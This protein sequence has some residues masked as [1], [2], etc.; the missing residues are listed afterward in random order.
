[1]S[2]GVT[3]VDQALP[4]VRQLLAA[5]KATYRIVGGLA[6]IHHGYHRA[7]V[8]IDLLIDRSTLEE[9]DREALGFVRTSAR[10]LRHEATGVGVGLLVAGEAMPRSS[11]HCYPAPAS[12]A[13][14]ATAPDVIALP[15]LLELKLCAGRYQDK[16]DVVELLKLL[17]E[18]EYLVVE[19]EL[20][21]DLRPEL[22][23]LRD[24]A[25]EEK[26]FER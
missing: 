22:A 17:E 12:M 13:A 11:G 3:A 20:P 7:T 16:A 24:D 4:A 26:R 8:D 25:L 1:M 10:R 18:G 6:V 23:R 5:A 9:L 14:S 21:A 15:G 2:D 19:S